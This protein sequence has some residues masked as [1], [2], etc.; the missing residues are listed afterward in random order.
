M[1]QA[2]LW[3]LLVLLVLTA[4][5]FTIAFASE[6]RVVLVIGNSAYRHAA[7]VDNPKND[8]ADM[9]AAAEKLGFEVIKR[10]DLDKSGV[11]RHRFSCL[12]TVSLL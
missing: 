11:D 1:F 10:L 4:S 3:N 12:W 5:S 9:A 6:N 8:A 7:V 2:V